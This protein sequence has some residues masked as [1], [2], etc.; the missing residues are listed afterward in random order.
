MHRI[1]RA[2]WLRSGSRRPHRR[3]DKSGF[4]SHHVVQAIIASSLSLVYIAP[5]YPFLVDRPSNIQCT[6]L[7]MLVLPAFFAPPPAIHLSADLSEIKLQ[8]TPPPQLVARNSSASLQ[9]SLPG[10]VAP[11]AGGRTNHGRTPQGRSEPPC[12]YKSLTLYTGF[13]AFRC[14][15]RSTGSAA[16]CAHYPIQ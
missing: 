11:Q 5:H 3:A 10:P 13:V 4:S 7:H 6:T 16:Q 1:N 14:V 12:T 15:H 8:I 2:L 9:F